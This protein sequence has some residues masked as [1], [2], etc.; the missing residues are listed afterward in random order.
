MPYC[1]VLCSRVLLPPI[2]VLN[3]S[4]GVLLHAPLLLATTI[5]LLLCC[6]PLSVFVEALDKCFENVCELDLIFHSDKVHNYTTF[7]TQERSLSYSLHLYLDRGAVYNLR[8]GML[9]DRKPV[10]CHPKHRKRLVRYGI[11]CMPPLPSLSLLV[12]TLGLFYILVDVTGQVT[13]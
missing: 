4:Y 3:I 2:C 13:V 10:Y 12:S 6:A 9:V 11:Q 5:L 1:L 8:V 7:P